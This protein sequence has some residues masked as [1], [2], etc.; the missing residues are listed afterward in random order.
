MG[1][2]ELAD[3]AAIRMWRLAQEHWG[4]GRQCI[5][6]EIFEHFEAG[7]KLIQAGLAEMREGVVYVRGSS[8]YLDWH[9]EKREAA[10]KGGKKSALRPR[11]A[12]GQLVKS[13]KQ[14]PSEVQAKT[15]QSQ[16][17][18]SDSGSGSLSVSG[19][20]FGNEN[21]TDSKPQAFIAR[22]CELFKLRWGVNPMI[23]KK[24]AGIVGRLSRVMGQERFE[25]LL[26]AYFSMP[27]AWIVKAKHPLG[28]FE[29]KLNEI[30][31]FAETGNFTTS[32]EVRNAD[33]MAAN[34]QLLK[35]IEEG[36]L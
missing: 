33:D 28:V 32:R 24:D 8:Q 20:D 10:K 5:P 15:K 29:T 35:K 34:M 17:S 14:K 25:T 36:K 6:I 22:Y 12:K 26:E 23:Q 1:A 19:T 16:P 21:P 2:E 11:N 13:S 18:G 31:V 3:A 30:S 4:M 27:D 9:A 7:P